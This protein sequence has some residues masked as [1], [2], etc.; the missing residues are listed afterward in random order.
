MHRIEAIAEREFDTL[1][2][3]N[4]WIEENEYNIKVISVQRELDGYVLFFG[5]VVSL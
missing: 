2:E 5:I 3:M 1:K 4:E